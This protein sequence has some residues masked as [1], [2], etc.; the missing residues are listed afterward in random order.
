VR[1]VEAFLKP[2]LALYIVYNLHN[3]KDTRGFPSRILEVR[4]L[5]EILNLHC[6][7]IVA[8]IQYKSGSHLTCKMRDGTALK[9]TKRKF[10][11]LYV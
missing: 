9:D 2:A 4:W 5:P 7:A 6:C 1:L 11:K 10:P 3:Y 8:T